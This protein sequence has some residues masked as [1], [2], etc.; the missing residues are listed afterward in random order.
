MG[1][2][3][4]AWT[5]RRLQMALSLLI[6]LF[7]F[8]SVSP[9]HANSLPLKIEANNA[10][11]MAG[12]P[13]TVTVYMDP[14]DHEFWSYETEVAYDPNVLQFVQATDDADS[15]SFTGQST[16][17]GTVHVEA[18]ILSYVVQRQ[19]MFTLH[20][21]I[22][23]AAVSGDTPITITSGSYTSGDDPETIQPPNIISGK[24]SVTA[25]PKHVTVGAG[26]ANG[27]AGGTVSVPVSVI[28][29]SAAGIAS[30]GMQLDFDPSALEV[31]DITGNSGNFFYSSS[32][33]AA[34]SL[35]AAWVD[36]S[37][38]D[39]P[40]V[41]GNLLFTV[42]FKIKPGASPGDKALTVNPADALHF[43]FTDGAAVEMVKTWAP[44]KVAVAS[45]YNGDGDGVT[46]ISLTGGN[47]AVPVPTPA[48]SNH[49][50][51]DTGASVLVNGK[52]ERAGTATTA[53]VNGRTVTT[54]VLDQMKLEESLASE[55]TH[56]VITIPVSAAADAVIG[57]LNGQMVQN[58]ERKQAVVVMKTDRATYTLPADQINIGAISSQLGKNIELKEIK[59]QIEIASPAADTI[60]IVENAAAQGGFE[61]VIPP[62]SFTV[63]G[64]YGDQTFET[65]QFNAFVE[66]SFALPDGVD[67]SKVTTGVVVDPDGTVRHVPT[68]VVQIDGKYYAQ[69]NSLT[70]STYSV[71][72][73]PLAFSDVADHWAKAE[74]NDMGSR[75]VID[76][77]GGGL[78]QPDRDMT[79]AEFAA[80]IVR[81]LGLRLEGGAAPF[82]DVQAADW[83][84]SAV[85]TA[86]AYQLID[87]FEDGTFRP[88]ET[89]TRE[90]AM[91]IIAKAMKVTGLKGKLPAATDDL[92]Q[93]FADA[94]AASGWAK[95]SIADV[96]QAGIVSGRTDAELAPQ[97]PISRAE[98][99]AIVQRLL[100]KSGLI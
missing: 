100:Q 4:F 74:V 14:R 26:T 17:S 82:Q 57:E 95:G 3:T 28:S 51:A 86:A 70:N 80:V 25:A 63:K 73:H 49:G 38:G 60:T 16:V 43:T 62:L 47:G 69:V 7:S 64:V 50:G 46:S 93:P 34:G 8:L 98:V 81:G 77:V 27:S 45:P 33:N 84:G 54:V 67:P 91:A 76:G 20:F 1:I 18:M 39:H 37:G 71:V 30:Y 75:M 85:R 29:A 11:G 41:A 32:D 23:D 58:M 66:R 48:P 52:I 12:D 10:A 90:Q 55:G 13:V 89:V 99:A 5:G 15:D 68:K 2:Q 53:E 83:F 21:V 24:V 88:N 92:L 61:L 87:G 56:A 19:P 44:S 35:K 6:A 78:F 36:A 94:A 65:K 42:T 40:A 96:L 22:K 79:R 59:I 97:A 31:T 72:W 9:A